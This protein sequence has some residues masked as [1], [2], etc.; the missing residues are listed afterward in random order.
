MRDHPVCGE[1]KIPLAVSAVFAE[2]GHA[3]DADDD[4]NPLAI[5]PKSDSFAPNITFGTKSRFPRNGQHPSQSQQPSHSE[6]VEERDIL[7]Q[8]AERV[9]ERDVLAQEVRSHF[10]S[11]AKGT[12]QTIS[13]QRALSP[14]HLDS[15]RTAI[16][17]S[18]T[19]GSKFSQNSNSLFPILPPLPPSLV[20]N[21]IKSRRS[22]HIYIYIYIWLYIYIYIYINVCM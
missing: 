14:V 19:L 3:D 2:E 10:G 20:N 12:S 5:G 11:S 4:D 1:P 21:N 15:C 13:R 9:E 17:F 6:W 22:I 16:P 8:E 18:V 7:A